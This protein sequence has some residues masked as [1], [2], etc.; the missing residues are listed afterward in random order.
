LASPEQEPTGLSVVMAGLV[1]LIHVFV[2]GK[3]E[4]VDHGVKPGDDI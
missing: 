4:N 3:R 1:P 2:A